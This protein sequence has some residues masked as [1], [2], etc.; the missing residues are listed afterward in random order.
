MGVNLVSGGEGV[1]LLFTG[2]DLSSV[3][4]SLFSHFTL[5]SSCLLG[6]SGVQV[7]FGE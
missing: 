5:V 3:N 7:N 1:C 2:R 4:F 6:F